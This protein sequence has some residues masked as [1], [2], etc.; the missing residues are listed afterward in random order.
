[1][2]HISYKEAID[3]INSLNIIA[4][5]K[6]VFLAD[7]LNH[8]L[9]CNIKAFVNSPAY[10]TAAMDGY[11]IKLQDNNQKVFNIADIAPAGS[12]TQVEVE[13]TTCIKAFTGSLMPKG[14]DTLIPIEFVEVKNNQI[15]IKQEVDIGYAVM[16][17][18]ENYKKDEILIPKGTKIDFAQIGVMA[19]LNIVYVEVFTSPKVSIC[20]TGSEILDLGESAV[21]HSQIR[22]SN[23]L[24]LEALTH[25]YGCESIMLGLI[26]DDKE[27]I[28]EAIK[29]GLNQSDIVV[30]TGGVSVGDYDFVKDIVKKELD[31]EVIFQ[32]VRIKPG[33]H[34]IVAQK[35][36]KF[37]CALPGFAYSSTVCFLLFCL[38]IIFAFR[39]GSQKLPIV[40]A[41][42][43]NDYINQTIKTLFIA[44]DLD[45]KDNIYTISNS[46]KRSGT[47]AILTNLLGDVAL[48]I[49]DEESSYKKGDFI[50]TILLR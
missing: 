46:S 41:K 40:K 38:P 34:I 35:G 49:V 28:L 20:S 6:K 18:G 44:S 15:H 5:T 10:P 14:S 42:A 45:Y 3:K 13:Q 37:I 8:I 31:A 7:S 2:A 33:Q 39:G 25:K 23:H 16:K 22:S 50:D 48:A 36:N 4:N 26:K 9:A 43:M 11:A 47:S 21:N 27:S 12:V 29:N 19:S 1:M 32:G 30:T 24:T 17:V